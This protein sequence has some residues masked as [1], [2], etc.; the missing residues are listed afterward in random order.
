MILE[1]ANLQWVHPGLVLIVGAWAIPFLKGRIK[2]SAMLLLPAIALFVCLRMTPG[3]YG[4][5]SFLG[6]DL[7]LAAWTS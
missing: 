7:V 2:R 5:V 6:Q 4:E 1:F 3:S